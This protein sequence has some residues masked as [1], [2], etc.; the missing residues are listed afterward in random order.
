MFY[1]L[2]FY[3]MTISEVFFI[4]PRVFVC[5]R[6]VILHFLLNGVSREYLQIG[7]YKNKGT[8]PNEQGN[9]S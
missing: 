7:F 3:F 2:C 6:G 9:I 8:F 5:F 4:V 1:V